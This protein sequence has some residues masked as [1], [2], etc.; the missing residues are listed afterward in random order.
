[1]GEKRHRGKRDRRSAGEDVFRAQSVAD[2]PGHDAFSG[3][4][5][6]PVGRVVFEELGDSAARTS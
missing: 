6:L 4:N 5:I 2:L 3:G 1:M